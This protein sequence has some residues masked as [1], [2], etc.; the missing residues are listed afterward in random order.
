MEKII[1]SILFIVSQITFGAEI[2]TLNL[3]KNEKLEGSFSI[4]NNK[5]ETTH[6]LFIKNSETKKYIIK[7]FL[8]SENNV[9]SEIQNVIVEKKPNIIANFSDKK[10][11]TI[12]SYDESDKILTLIEFD[13]ATG[14]AKYNEIFKYQKPDIILNQNN[15]ILFLKFLDSGKKISLDIITNELKI[16]SKTYIPSEDI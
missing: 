7:P 4:V 6:L 5:N 3:G 15:Q 14:K 16:S 10:H 13:L 9:V 2:F 1:F 11:M 12:S 8:F